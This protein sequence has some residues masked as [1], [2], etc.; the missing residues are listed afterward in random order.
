MVGREEEGEYSRLGC[1]GRSFVEVHKIERGG[2]YSRGETGVVC[3]DYRNIMREK[4]QKR[5]FFFI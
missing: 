2:K 1:E 4:N 3:G 5:A